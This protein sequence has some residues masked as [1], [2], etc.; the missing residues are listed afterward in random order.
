MDF[1]TGRSRGLTWWAGAGGMLM[2]PCPG[3]AHAGSLRLPRSEGGPL[4][5]GLAGAGEELHP[6]ESQPPQQAGLW[7]GCPDQ[8][9]DGG[10]AGG[11][12]RPLGQVGGPAE[13]ASLAAEESETLVS[14]SLGWLGFSHME[15]SG[16]VTWNTLNIQPEVHRLFPLS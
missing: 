14:A 8:G 13:E 7:E 4:W 3:G 10:E 11:A 9:W 2:P 16:L 6:G 15:D 5:A 12:D 1:E